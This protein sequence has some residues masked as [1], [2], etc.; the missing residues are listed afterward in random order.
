MTRSRPGPRPPRR[1]GFT[2]VEVMFALV[3]TGVLMG[4]LYQIFFATTSQ[5]HKI[6]AKYEAMRSALV[7]SEVISREVDRLVTLE[8]E[9][10][11]EGAVVPIYGDHERPVY[12][13]RDGRGVSFFVPAERPLE[14]GSDEVAEPMMLS[15]A[16]AET[17]GVF[18]LKRDEGKV[19]VEAA[20]AAAEAAAGGEGEEAEEAIVEGPVLGSRVLKGVHLRSLKYRLLSPRAESEANRSPD[21]NFYLEAVIVGT[22]RKGREENA[23]TVLK[24]L[25]Y[26]SRRLSD[27]QVGAVAYAPRAPLQPPSVV[28]NPTP[29]EERV[30]E[31]LIRIADAW[32]AGE[33]DPQELV[34]AARDALTPVVGKVPTGALTSNDPQIRGLPP[35]ATVLTPPGAPV[36]AIGSPDGPVVLLP[37]RGG[38]EPVPISEVTPQG[39]EVWFTGWAKSL[40]G[41]GDVIFESG[42]EGGGT[43]GSNPGD[44][45]WN[46]ITNMMNNNMADLENSAITAA[47][48][49]MANQPWSNGGS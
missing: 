21:D 47:N 35:N 7:A 9:R 31:E 10:D 27:P 22:D 49:W 30:A 40:T 29:E 18:L 14:A 41:D 20:H 23:L 32:E 34:D 45:S 37:P 16:K 48:D 24:P 6:D 4:T 8:V 25:L 33:L 39:E 44:E 12:I 3:I 2:L 19:A 28:V 17:G 26:P 15:L 11:E 13:G 1:R 46:S 43:V 5:S 42:F 36:T 38:P